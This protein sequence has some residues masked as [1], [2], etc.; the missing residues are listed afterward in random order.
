MSASND[1]RMFIKC[2]SADKDQ[3]KQAAEQSGR[4]LSNWVIWNLN[5]IAENELKAAEKKSK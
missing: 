4:S 3:W 2:R 1:D 5:I